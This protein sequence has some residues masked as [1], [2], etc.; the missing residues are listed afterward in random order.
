MNNDVLFFAQGGHGL[1]LPEIG[2]C[3]LV[4]RQSVVELSTTGLHATNIAETRGWEIVIFP[5]ADL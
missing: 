2:N 1:L 5:E 4:E 3:D